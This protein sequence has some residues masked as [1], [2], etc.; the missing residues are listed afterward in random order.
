[1]YIW[2]RLYENGQGKNK[3]K[4]TLQTDRKLN[5]VHKFIGFFVVNPLIG[6]RSVA[7]IICTTPEYCLNL[8]E[9]TIFSACIICSSAEPDLL[10]ALRCVFSHAL[11]PLVLEGKVHLRSDP[12]SPAVSW[13]AFFLKC[14]GAFRVFVSWL[15]FAFYYGWW[16]LVALKAPVL[17]ILE[18]R[19]VFE[20]IYL[21]LEIAEADLMKWLL[22]CLLTWK[23][24]VKRNK[25]F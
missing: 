16:H 8:H 10:L 5:A 20:D 25:D 6:L 11:G 18:S 7:S 21:M 19:A 14:E 22:N 24:Y 17:L 12:L 1:M 9:E 4:A 13:R 15:S 2:T 23:E 3:R